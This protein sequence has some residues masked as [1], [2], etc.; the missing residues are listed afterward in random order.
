MSVAEMSKI[1]GRAMTGDV[2]MLARTLG[3][4]KEALAKLSPEFAKFMETA[5]G[6]QETQLGE[7]TRIGGEAETVAGDAL[8]ALDE[9]TNALGA[10]QEAISEYAST[11]GG[12][13]ETLQGIWENFTEDIGNE[14]L[15]VI[16]EALGKLI[17]FITDHKEDIDK[18]V[19]AFGDL[20][21]QGFEK[22]MQFLD[23][24][25]AEKLFAALGNFSAEQWKNFADA[26]SSVKWEDVANAVNG[27]TDFVNFLSG[28]KNP[29]P[30]EERAI[31]M[32]IIGSISKPEYAPEN[33]NDFSWEN[34]WSTAAKGLGLSG[35][36]EI[37]VKVSIDDEMRLRA[38]YDKSTDEKLDDL[39]SGV[40]GGNN[41]V[42]KN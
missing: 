9:I 5:Q 37:E 3:I 2:E 23:S 33:M 35:K 10:G 4:S 16:Q 24:G 6:A 12:E 34:F 27:V 14:L 20:A 13:V 31:D 41:K 26:I 38:V 11:A 15:P 8:K 28:N 17:V 39:V 21:E 25:E 1:V 30:E 19:G 36:Q 29:V 42:A 32:G 40:T 22:L 7:V 18:F